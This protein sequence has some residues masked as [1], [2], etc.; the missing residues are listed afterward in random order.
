MRA[1]LELP[2]PRD[3]AVAEDTN[4]PQVSHTS[5]CKCT[6]RTCLMPPPVGV[7]LVEY[8]LGEVRIVLPTV[9]ADAVGGLGHTRQQRQP[10]TCGAE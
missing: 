3:R 5:T 6:D 2:G 9:Q 1:R 8:T 7:Q 4:Q 10:G